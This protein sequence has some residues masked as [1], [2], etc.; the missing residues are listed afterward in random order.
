MNKIINQ[1]G[2]HRCLTIYDE[3]AVLRAPSVLRIIGQGRS[4]DIICAIAL[5][6]Y[7]QLKQV[8]S[9]EEAET[10]FNMTGN[11]IAGQVSGETA[12]LLSERFPKIMQDR[13]SISINRNDTSFSRSKQLEA[14][15]PPSTIST[16]SSGE[17]VGIVA[18]N[19][20]QPI[21]LKA[22]HCK[23]IN[24][25]EA[26]RKEK[27][28]F[29]PV[30]VSEKAKDQNEILFNYMQIKED[31]QEIAETIMEELLNDPAKEHLVIRK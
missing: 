5:Q 17:F 14:S 3:F 21:E 23:V 18:D 30:P 29:Q 9:R 19:P 24:N 16:L 28:S 1:P 27:L 10:I 8:Y 25:H 26:L 22:V 20:D 12:K 13:E 15:I 7:S 31:V 11:V 6:D 4:N 2:K